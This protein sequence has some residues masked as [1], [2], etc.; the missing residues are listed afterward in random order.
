VRNPLTGAPIPSASNPGFYDQRELDPS[1]GAVLPA[2]G[3]II[4]L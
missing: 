2:L 4:E 1:T 3:L